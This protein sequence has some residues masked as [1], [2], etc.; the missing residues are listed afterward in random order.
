MI[1]DDVRVPR[2]AV[3][4]LQKAYAERTSD[5]QLERHAGL[6]RPVEASVLVIRVRSVDLNG[7]PFQV[8]AQFLSTPALL[9]RNPDRLVPHPEVCLPYV[10]TGV[11]LKG[12]GRGRDPMLQRACEDL[13]E[14]LREKYGAM[15]GLQVSAGRQH[16]KATD[17]KQRFVEAD[18]TRPECCFIRY[19]RSDA[20]VLARNEGWEEYLAHLRER[21]LDVR[22]TR[23]DARG[24]L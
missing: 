20:E 12:R 11:E 9:A 7:Y 2:R 4:A 8:R 10:L 3:A 6:E 15:P 22:K 21:E 16:L 18:A 5:K 13:V 17:A 1:H 19:R 24:D 14:S 23:P